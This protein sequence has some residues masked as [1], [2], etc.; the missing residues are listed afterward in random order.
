VVFGGNKH[1]IKPF[2]ING[3]D[4]VD[5][6]VFD[7]GDEGISGSKDEP[8]KLILSD[9]KGG[10]DL[11][12]I[13][14]SEQEWPSSKKEKGELGDLNGDGIL[15][16]VLPTNM[17]IYIY[18]G[19]K[20]FPFFTQNN[21]A[22]FIGDFANFGNLGDNGFG[23]KVPYVAGNAFTT[24]ICDINKDGN[25]DIFIGVGEEHEATLFPKQP[26]ILINQGGG[27]FN[28][29][30]N[31]K[32]PFF[33]PNDN[34]NNSVQDII[35]EDINGDGLNDLIAVNDQMYRNPNSWAPYEIFAYMQQQDGTFVIDKNLVK[36]KSA[37]RK[38]NWKPH[39]I[40]YDFNGDGK[41]DLSYL[42][43]ADNGELVSKT[44]FIRE[45]NNFIEQD[46]FQFD[47]YANSLRGLI[48]Q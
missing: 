13:A 17:F 43:D 16:L 7:N 24:L 46:F 38:G 5:L 14:T 9:S 25:N 28:S 18:W 6:I 42:D 10:Y 30:G 15:D 32:L 37:N 36:Y 2:Y 4:Y 20:D 12:E 31:I 26:R 27:R 39:L 33:Y 44:V 34:I 19:Q 41:K 11:K 22:K 3:D 45:G 29:N 40:Y 8:I 47:S 35:M 21:R 1:T 23:E 48:K